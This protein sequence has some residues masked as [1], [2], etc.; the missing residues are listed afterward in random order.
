MSERLDE[1]ATEPSTLIELLRW[2]ALHQPDR[3]AYTFLVDGETEKAHLTYSELD[4]QARAIAA[5]LQS[6][7]A[8]GQRALLLYPPGLEFIA[9][10]F[11]C[12]YSGAIAVPVYPPDPV[13]L[14]RMR[15]RLQAIAHDAQP[16]MALTT[17][18]LLSTV[19]Q[20]FEQQTDFDNM[21]RLDTDNLVIDGA[22]EWRDPA[23]PRRGSLIVQNSTIGGGGL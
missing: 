15:R 14:D 3:R 23:A 11:G 13:L 2:R 20:L 21:L 17:S 9:A 1:W 7:G 5:L 10:F 12:L 4:R 18:P 22:N 8:A 6:L 16:A 19:D